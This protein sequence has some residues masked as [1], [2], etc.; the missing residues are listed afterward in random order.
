MV[1]N[2]NDEENH[3]RRNLYAGKQKFTE[4]KNRDEAK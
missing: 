4:F 3:I 1:Y 2:E